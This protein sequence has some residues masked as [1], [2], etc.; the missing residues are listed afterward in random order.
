MATNQQFTEKE[1]LQLISRMIHEAKGYFHESGMAAL[2]YGFSILACS[3][4]AFLSEKNI[5]VFPFHPFWLFVPLF[6]IQSWIQV[7]EEKKK[8]AKTFT[9]E[10]IDY[11]WMGYFLSVFA[12]FTATFAG[13]NYVIISVIL[14]LTGLAIFLTGMIS[15]FRYNIIASFVIWILAAVSFFIQN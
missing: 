13:F 14:L 10:A 2:V 3:V 11:V 15:K 12:T 1:S 5:I 4:L 7:K 8:K 9:D 6:F